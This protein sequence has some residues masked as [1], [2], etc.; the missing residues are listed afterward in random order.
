MSTQV[1][2][3]PK[4]SASVLF[5]SAPVDTAPEQAITMAKLA[6]TRSARTPKTVRETYVGSVNADLGLG[7][8]GDVESRCASGVELSLRVFRGCPVA[9][10]YSWA[11]AHISPLANLEC[12][13]VMELV[14]SGRC[15][16]RI[17]LSPQ[18][19]WQAR[20]G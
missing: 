8:N 5:A 4:T 12:R 18:R 17:P 9:R 10:V 20:G 7:R 3:P 15:L 2:R 6:A 14:E 11:S 13:E 16:L 1:P 19:I